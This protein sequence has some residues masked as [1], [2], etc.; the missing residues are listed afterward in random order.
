MS[1]QPWASLCRTCSETLAA[2]SSA[3]AARSLSRPSC[4]FRHL[5]LRKGARV[6]GRVRESAVQ[7]GH[8]QLSCERG[9]EDRV[10]QAAEGY[11]ACGISQVDDLRCKNGSR[12]PTIRAHR[13]A[14]SKPAM[15]ER[16]RQFKFCAARPLLSVS[17]HFGIETP[18]RCGVAC[19]Q[20]P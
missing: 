20:V 9:L 4:K 8:R 15:Q 7:G 6:W 18:S 10:P 11:G 2:R 13:D 3:L 14:G 1:E 5:E 19:G 16:S 12:K 17:Q